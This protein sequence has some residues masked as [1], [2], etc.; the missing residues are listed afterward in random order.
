MS[1]QGTDESAAPQSVMTFLRGFIRS[2]LLGKYDLF[3]KPATTFRDHALDGILRR[4]RIPDVQVAALGLSHQVLTSD[5][6]T[7]WITWERVEAVR[8]CARHPL[9]QQAHLALDRSPA[10]QV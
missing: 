3:R 5:R 7:P 2:T 8:S 9:A 10:W 4:N 1:Y 6:I